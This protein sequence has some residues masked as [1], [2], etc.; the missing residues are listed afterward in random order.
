MSINQSN[1]KERWQIYLKSGRDD[2]EQVS[3]DV[4][5]KQVRV[6]CVAQ[7]AEVSV[8]ISPDTTVQ[9]TDKK[10]DMLLDSMFGLF[11][12]FSFCLST[13][14]IRKFQSTVLLR[15]HQDR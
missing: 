7:A 8:L 3:H 13:M 2:P 10:H 1:D 12:S 9:K 11:P 5:D 14:V 6:D 15:P 4:R